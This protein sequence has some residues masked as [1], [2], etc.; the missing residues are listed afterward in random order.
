VKGILP[1]EAASLIIDAQ[2]KNYENTSIPSF[3]LPFFK[4]IRYVNR[5]NKNLIIIYA[6]CIFE[7]ILYNKLQNN[8]L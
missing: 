3:F 1:Q 8:S 6:Q 5:E 7:C 2:R 4:I